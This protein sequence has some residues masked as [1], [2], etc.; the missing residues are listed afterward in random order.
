MKYI[1]FL[2]LI[3][4]L[5]N[6]TIAQTHAADEMLICTMRYE[7]V[8]GVDGAT[9]W[10]SCSAGDTEIA[11]QG[12]CKT[13]DTYSDSTSFLEAEWNSCSV[14]TDGC[15]TVHILDGVLGAMTRMYC[16][17]IYGDLW[18]EQWSCIDDELEEERIW[19]LSE[20]DR[21]QYYHFQDSLWIEASEKIE[22]FVETFWETLLEKSLYKTS[23][24]IAV[25]KSAIS[26]F[27]EATSALI[28]SYPADSAMSHKDTEKYYIL[29]VAKVELQI[30]MERWRKNSGM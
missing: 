15:N 28:L 9:Y 3:V 10:N 16:E 4:W 24:A 30:M 17:D 23:E 20:N 29:S 22:S 18:Q 27:E 6:I 14:A 12:E 11:Y 1:V 26:R 19:F 8:C 25:I 13:Q 5:F 2:S 21:N 7:P